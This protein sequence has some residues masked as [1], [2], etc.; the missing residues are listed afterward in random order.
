M[1]YRSFKEILGETSLER[2]CRFLFGLCLLLLITGSFW[3]YGRRTEDLVYTTTRST[4]R[5]L[6]DAVMLHHHWKTLEADKK[7]TS[8]IESLGQQLQSQPYSWK[9][10]RPDATP[11]QRTSYT[12]LDAAVLNYFRQQPAASVSGAAEPATSPML[13]GDSDEYREF[14]TADNSEYHYYQPIRARSRCLICH[15]NRGG[16]TATGEVAAGPK[17]AGKRADGGGQGGDARLGNQY[18]INWN[19]GDPAGHGDRDVAL[20]MLAAYAYRAILDRQTA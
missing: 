5:H 6:V 13:P 14:R 12:Q 19:R 8:L 16:S 10:L 4:G 15:E 3:W 18:A 9:I 11:D 7:Y 17:L 20:A 1:S 2:K